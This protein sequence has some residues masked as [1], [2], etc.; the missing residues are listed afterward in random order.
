MRKSNIDTKVRAVGCS[1]GI[2]FSSGL[3]DF[4]TFVGITNADDYRGQL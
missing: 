2:Q 1:P 4:L 3:V